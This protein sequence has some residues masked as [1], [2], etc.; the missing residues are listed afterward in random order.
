MP[1]PGW[2]AAA[3]AKRVTSAQRDVRPRDRHRCPALFKAFTARLRSPGRTLSSAH[4]PGGT[5]RFTANTP[6]VSPGTNAGMPC[7]SSPP[8]ARA[9]S[10]G[11]SKV[12]T[13]TSSSRV[14][15]QTESPE[16]PDGPKVTRGNSEAIDFGCR[17]VSGVSGTIRLPSTNLRDQSSY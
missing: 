2:S 11:F 14:I 8:R 1:Y 10:A 17:A 9:A 16:R 3:T 6:V 4:V 13:V 5:D 7:A 15:Q 12:A